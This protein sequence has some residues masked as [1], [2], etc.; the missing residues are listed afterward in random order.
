MVE[1]GKYSYGNPQTIWGNEHT[2]VTVGKF[3]SIAGNVL[4]WLG[5]GRGHDKGFIST[6]PFGYIHGEIFGN[7]QNNSN[8]GLLSVTIGNDV[9]I[10]QNVNIMSGVNI[11]DGAIIAANSHVV[12]DVPPYAIVGGNPAN[13]IKYR[14]TENQIQKLLQIQWWDW[15]ESKINDNMNSIL[16]Y[17]IESFIAK[18]S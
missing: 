15:P 3:T 16:S 13:I 14:F 10:G 6:Y 8:D 7:A 2:K 1:L 11:G 9:W 17:D 4:I 5:N 12:K 18:H